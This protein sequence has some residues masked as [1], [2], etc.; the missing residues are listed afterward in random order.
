[1]RNTIVAI[2][3]L[4]LVAGAA[5]AGPDGILSST[6]KIPVVKESGEPNKGLLDCSGAIEI[7]LDNVYY[8]DNTGMPNNVTTYGCSTWNESGGEVVY[9]LYLAEPAMFEAYITPSGCDLDLAVLDQ[10]DEDLGCLI[11]VDSGVVTNV[12]VTGDFYFVVDGY[13]GAECPFTFEII[14]VPVPEPVE[15]CSA[16]EEV[17][18]TYFEGDTCGGVNNIATLDCGDYTENGLE[19]YYEVFMPAGS[20]FTADVTYATADGAL[21]VLDACNEPF[22]CLGYADN[23][24]SGE[25]ETVTYTNDTGSDTYVYL[26]IDSWGTGACGTYVMDFASTGGAI[27]AE[28]RSFGNV[29]AMFR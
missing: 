16:V 26:V 8:G 15:F 4:A 9:H 3:A 19:Y 2:I 28:S 20:T 23:T 13:A 12:P 10:C 27:P 11:V 21:W 6:S 1:M 5:S 14:S 7:S 22:N 17:Y 24:L 18:G 29:K 25:T